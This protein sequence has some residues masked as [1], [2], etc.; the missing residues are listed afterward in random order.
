LRVVCRKLQR[1]K[2]IMPHFEKARRIFE[3]YK[4]I[5]CDRVITKKPGEYSEEDLEKCKLY[6]GLAALAEGLAALNTRV[7]NLDRR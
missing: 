1:R 2:Q 7:A 6:T 5:Y 4:T 3:E